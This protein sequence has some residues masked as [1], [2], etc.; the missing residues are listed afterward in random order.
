MLQKGI[1]MEMNKKFIVMMTSDGQ[2]IRVQRR[3]MACQVGEEIT[4]PAQARGPSGFRNL[5]RASYLSAAA[6][7]VFVMFAALS[8][9]NE[10]IL[11]DEV[12][13]YVTI[14]INPSVEAGLNAVE[15]VVEV[16][17]INEDGKALI[18]GFNYYGLSIDAFSEA[19]VERLEQADYLNKTELDI[20]ITSTIVSK[21][22]D[23]T[24]SELSIK[25]EQKVIETLESK[26]AAK[27]V[28]QEIVVTALTAPKEVRK[29]AAR[30]GVSTGKVAAQMIVEDAAKA[31]DV[32]KDVQT[33]S[34]KEILSSLKEKQKELEQARKK[35]EK[36][37]KQPKQPKQ[38]EK[39]N[40]Q[41]QKKVEQ[42]AKKKEQQAKK[43]EQQEERKKE[44]QQKKKEQ[45][46][47]KKEQQE[48]IKAQQAKKKEQEQQ[49]KKKK[50][51]EKKQQEKKE[52]EKK[53]QQEKNQR[54]KEA[55]KNKSSD[56]RKKS[57]SPD[58]KKDREQDKKSGN[59]S[60][61]NERGAG[62]ENQD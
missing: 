36:E 32:S 19:I 34:V 14:D 15:E 8:L 45:Q 22:S 24:D 4:V 23:M 56:D 2:F 52:Q 61:I 5:M 11:Q 33:K 1:V 30:Q 54:A 27:P 25:V 55:N 17:G 3:G 12:V 41:Q 37:A 39:L 48:K 59:G 9:F 47:K 26:T 20:L 35:K 50:Q 21:R 16:R 57:A 7:L 40:E 38:Q 29:E 31:K 53:K 43:K 42:Q 18:A 58:D 62:R 60:K 28:K 44:Q 13:A 6:V 49:A 10:G 51:Q 46:E